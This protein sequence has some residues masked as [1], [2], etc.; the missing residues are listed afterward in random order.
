MKKRTKIILF[1]VIPVI[2]LVLGA[3][4]IAAI[5]KSKSGDKPIKVRAEAVQRG[6]LI[7]TINAPGAIEPLTKV[8]ISAKVSARVMEL[9]FEEGDRVSAD[10]VVVRLD[11]KDLESQL[12]SAQASRNAEKAQ[13]EVEKIRIES[14]KASL[15]G[16][17]A[18]FEQA[19]TDF[20]RKKQLLTSKD[21]SQSDFDQAEVT[22]LDL[23]AQ[24]LQAEQNIKASE[25]SLI[26]MEHRLQ[27]ADARVEEAK[28]A[29]S[30]TTIAAPM[31]GIIT[32]L[33]AEVGEVVMTG[34]MNNP[35]TIILTVADL[36]QMILNAQVDETNIGLIQVGQP[37][38][39]NVQAFWE[40]EFQGTV[41]SIALTNSLSNT[42]TKY[43]ETEIL[44]AGDVQK[45]YTGLTADVDIEVEVHEEV[46]KVPSQ[47]VLE[48][49]VDDL[50][51]K[52]RKDNPLV[53]PKKSFL[54][55]VYRIVD[56]K[57]AVTPVHVGS[58][59]MT[60]TIIE[61]GLSQNDQV[62]IGPYKTLETI[63]HDKPV[64]QEKENE[65]EQDSDEEKTE[66]KE[67]DN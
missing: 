10:D 34:T 55:V 7:E 4:Q 25:L 20:D 41:K 22:L 9:P 53:D 65:K 39:V 49:K 23:E 59:D 52:I 56:N 32:R 6:K 57:T 24:I 18:R 64:E 47:A 28:E 26:V 19:Q 21:I 54:T 58:S 31:D 17:K 42:G 38:I 63:G 35:G 16:L 27:A 44:L 60:H 33:N 37:A 3:G 30:Y 2:F 61:E 46:L 48:R 36:S 12:S 62:V 5:K 66:K 13:I 1:V 40:D 11:A 8:D 15:K 51:E 67:E 45:L 14:Q 43:Y 50:P 29:L